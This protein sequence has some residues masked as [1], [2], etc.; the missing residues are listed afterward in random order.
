MSTN[1]ISEI[2]EWF[3][4]M[5]QLKILD[6]SFNDIQDIPPSFSQLSNLVMLSLQGNVFQEIPPPITLLSVPKNRIVSKKFPNEIMPHL[7]LGCLEC[8]QNKHALK[9]L[10][11]S[12]IVSCCG[13]K[14]EFFPELFKYFIID[15]DD[16]PD[17]NI[18]DYFEKAIHFINEAESQGKACLVHCAAGI[19]RS[20]TITIAY[21][22]VTQRLPFAEAR[23][24]VKQKRPIICPNEG[25]VVQLQNFEN[26]QFPKEKCQIQ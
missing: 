6:L 2:P 15:I 9:N 17:S 13:P 23:E 26:E 19:S 7:Y 1:S 18:S 10:N 24:Y 20:S 16:H 25:F 8:A 12:Y 22:M 21:V 5:T 14:T 3:C 11:I 4:G